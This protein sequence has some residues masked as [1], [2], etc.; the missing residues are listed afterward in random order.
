ML[1]WLYC[2]EAI[3]AAVYIDG[4]LDAAREFI[5]ESMGGMLDELD[6]DDMVFDDYKSIVQQIVQR[7]NRSLPEYRVVK[8]KQARACQNI[9]G[10]TVC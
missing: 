1:S 2:V 4:G 3:I 6:I 5:L 8:I 10:A 7:G 9:Y